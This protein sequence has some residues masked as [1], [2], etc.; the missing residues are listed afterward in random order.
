MVA[1]E[2]LTLAFE[3]LEIGKEYVGGNAVSRDAT[4]Y[5]AESAWKET[6]QTSIGV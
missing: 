4:G 2:E 1:V 6:S 3:G 5:F